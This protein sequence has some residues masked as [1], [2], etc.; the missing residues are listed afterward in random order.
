M[1][2]QLI[3]DENWNTEVMNSWS[4]SNILTRLIFPCRQGKEKP[5]MKTL[6]LHITVMESSQDM[7]SQI[8]IQNEYY[9]C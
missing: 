6:R 4:E 9:C 8:N 3:S 5:L 1:G 2:W 7:S